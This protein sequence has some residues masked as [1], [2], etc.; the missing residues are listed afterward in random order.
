MTFSGGGFSIDPRGNLPCDLIVGGG[1]DNNF[2][3][4]YAGTIRILNNSVL[5]A[6]ARLGVSNGLFDFGANNIT[7]AALN[8]VNQANNTVLY[9]PAT[10]VAGAGVFGTGTLRV[11]G[12]INVLGV[13]T[14]NFNSNSIGS[15]LDLGG[16]TQIV[17][18]ASNGSFANLRALQFTGV[19]SNGSLLKTFGYQENGIMGQPDGIGLFGNNTYTG[20]STFNGGRSI[21]TGTNATTWS[22]LW[23]IVVLSLRQV[24]RDAAGSNGSLLSATTIQAVAGG[25]FIID[26]NVALP[27]GGDTPTVPAAQNN[28]RIRDDAEIQLR[29]GTFIY[30]GQSATAASE[31]FGN[32]NVLGGHSNVTLSPG[33]R[34]DGNRDRERKP[35][36][37]AACHAPGQL[38]HARRREQVVCQRHAAGD[39][40]TGILQHMA[41]TTDFLTYNGTTGLTPFTGYATDFSTPGTNVAVTAASTVASSVNI[42][43]LKRTG[44]FT[45]TI[46]AGQTLGITSGM[47]LSVWYGHLY[48]RHDCVRLYPGVFFA[49]AGSGGFTIGSAITGTAG[50]INTNS[51]STLNGDL[52]G[53][54]GTIT[55]A[56]FNYHY[57]CD[58][59]LWWR[60]R[61]PRGNLNI[62]TSQ[63]LAGQGAITLGV[64]RTTPT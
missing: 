56:I 38:R 10:G 6:T 11:T 25:Q 60:D 44:T 47:L 53:L 48:R 16:G 22:G 57:A 42:N 43:A 27:A 4:I 31:T 29:D 55:N 50:L 33:R 5:P 26:N 62:N 59:H 13:N 40:A 9:N 18:V 24:A 3:P 36:A 19:L 17:R 15:N 1:S 2:N 39:D 7:I 51:V 21:I 64:P 28:D 61:S 8:F 63:T 58:K 41:S 20:S 52:S 30:R 35:H 37:G 34:G 23:A 46:A 45:T 12:E 32:L 14:A 54:T 49:R